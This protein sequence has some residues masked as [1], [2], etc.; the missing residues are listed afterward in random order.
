[1]YYIA[2]T[3]CYIAVFYFG[4]ILDD[5]IPNIRTLITPIVDFFLTNYAD[6][7]HFLILNYL[8]IKIFFSRSS[9]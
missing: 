1:M 3:N 6:F 4:Q 5:L 8:I 2:K 7:K 9:N